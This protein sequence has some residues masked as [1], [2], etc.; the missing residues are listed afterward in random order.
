MLLKNKQPKKLHIELSEVMKIYESILVDCPKCGKK[1]TPLGDS[2]VDPYHY[3]FDCKIEVP[4]ETKPSTNNAET[5]HESQ[6]PPKG[7]NLSDCGL[8]QKEKQT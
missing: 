1:M 5:N 2:C 4:W 7:V 8:D 6:L 3:C